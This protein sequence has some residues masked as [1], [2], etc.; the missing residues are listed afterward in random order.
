MA[1]RYWA[2]TLY[3]SSSTSRLD[4]DRYDALLIRVTLLP[5]R[6]VRG[7]RAEEWSRFLGWYEAPTTQCEHGKRPCTVAGFRNDR[8]NDIE[9]S[10][11]PARRLLRVCLGMTRSAESVRG[12]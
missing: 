2:R 8:A 3:E 4:T 12:D 10:G 5:E 6:H 9:T 7:A 1:L 11:T